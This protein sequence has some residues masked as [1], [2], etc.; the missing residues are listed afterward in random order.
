MKLRNP[1]SSKSKSSSNE[2]S[3]AGSFAKAPL[4]TY[5]LHEGEGEIV[6]DI[7]FVHGLR[8]HALETWSKGLVCWPRD[9]LKDDIPNARIITWGYDSGVANALKY[10]S[11]E[12]IFGH[13]ETL[14]GDI[15]R[16][17][18]DKALIKS[19]AYRSHGRH[20][21]L[22]EIYHNTKGAIFL[23]TPHRGS[24]KT[25]YANIITN[26]AKF[27]F[28]QPNKQLVGVLSPDSDV[29]ENQR[30]QFTTITQK[31]PIVCIREELPTAI[32]M[33]VPEFS[34]S[35]DGFNIRKDSIPA[36]HM[37]MTKFSKPQDIGYRRISGHI[38]SLVQIQAAEENEEIRKR[39]DDILQALCFETIDDREGKIDKAHAET[40]NWILS[41]QEPGSAGVGSS[42]SIVPW[43][44]KD[45][46]PICWVSGKA[47]SGK[48]T[49]MKYIWTDERTRTHLSTWARG[50]PLVL[51]AFFFIE[52][53]ESLQK[54]REGLIRSLL[55]QILS[56]QRGLIRMVF[57]HEFGVTGP[58]RSLS[59]SILKNAF[60]ILLSHTSDLFKLCIFADGLDEYRIMDR[61]EDYTDGDFDLFY[62][63]ENEDE[64]VWGRSHWISS[65]HEEIA[66]LFKMA[67]KTTNVKICLSSRELTTFQQAFEGFPRLRIHGLTG[68]DITIFTKARLLGDVQ[69]TP[70]VDETNGMDKLV[71]E[72]VLKAQGVFLWVRLVVD[73]MVVGFNN[74]DTIPELQS[75][76]DSL[77]PRLGG[78]KGLYVA[79]L[80]NI[81][82]EY[83]RQAS[84]Y[85]R[86]LLH[87]WNALDLVDLEFA[88]DGPFETNCISDVNPEN[89]SDKL[90]AVKAPFNLIPDEQL[91]PR[92][93]KM[94]MR[95]M[96]RCG[97]LL[98]A[99]EKHVAFMHQTVKEFFLRKEFWISLLPQ[100]SQSSFDPS[101]A[102]L[103]ACIRKLKC[104]EETIS[105]AQWRSFGS[106]YIY[107]ADSMHYAESAEGHGA[108]KKAYFC[109]LDELDLTCTKLSRILAR[110][111]FFDTDFVDGYHYHWTRFEPMKR[112]PSPVTEDDSFLSYAA[113]AGLAS[114]VESKLSGGDIPVGAK[115]GKP[116]L[117]YT[118]SFNP[119]GVPHLAIAFIPVLN[120]AAIRYNLP[121]IPVVKVLLSFGADTNERYCTDE[122]P[123]GER[124]GH[125]NE[126]Y[127]TT[128]WRKAVE[129]GEHIFNGRDGHSRSKGIPEAGRFARNERRWIE[130]MKIMLRHGANLEELCSMRKKGGGKG[131]SRYFD[132]PTKQALRWILERRPKY[133]KDLEELEQIIK[134]RVSTV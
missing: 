75:K 67:A 61:M 15:E 35:T 37:D 115:F 100:E 44:A 5:V 107:I 20:L 60:G 95:L 113:Q 105:M 102:L 111:P 54:S 85:I 108:N 56:Q 119:A 1:F 127:H 19:A 63:G 33:I 130:I 24:D 18:R 133:A 6:A 22:G 13:S 40:F 34:A 51:A 83:R 4:G 74:G 104:S 25:D 30:E 129:S 80:R 69:S 112:M 23:G 86:I 39:M 38:V 58:I 65:G 124:R 87:A 26:V 68:T 27:S 72:I 16:L 32:G 98:E 62:D 36:N 97:G 132:M 70:T 7:I 84:R 126:H 8:G 14:L 55:H 47:G 81:A 59:W 29:L 10:A 106:N 52:R 21:S 93:V 131:G 11:K 46:E 53:G 82:P 120:Y 99:P 42:S 57:E 45:N 71:E 121:D 117:A 28:R 134:E 48:S 3:Q 122:R 50:K 90:I 88:A 94:R 128:V 109:L 92:R 125:T 41:N 116:L 96:S 79:M 123:R 9:F 43:L 101:L 89:I 64:A 110:S 17:R 73:I 76:L 103:S 2:D 49:L 12:S 77:P 78:K 66:K 114:Y 31:T 91:E 118:V